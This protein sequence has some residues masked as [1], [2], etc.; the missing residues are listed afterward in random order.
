M[1]SLSKNIDSDK[2]FLINRSQIENRF[3]PKFYTSKYLNNIAKIESSQLPVV[4][5]SEV[6]ELISDG[7]HFTPK[8]TNKGVKFISV[9][10]VRKST[11]DLTNSK[12]IS[13]EEADKLDR[14]CKPKI[15]D[16]LL[17]KIGATFGLASVVS[18]T[19]RFQIFVSLALLRPNNG[20]NPKYLEIFLNS[21][22]AYIQYERVIKGAG[23]PDLHLEDIRKVKMPLPEKNE[24]EKIVS[25]YSMAFEEKQKK[26]QEAKSLRKSIDS[27][28]LEQLG[29]NIPT[30]D[31]SLSNRV[32]QVKWSEIFG[33]RLDGEFSQIYFREITK[34]VLEGKYKPS[35]IKAVTSFVESGSRPKGG[36]GQINSG[37]FS[38]GGEHVNDKCQVGF[39]KPKYIPI[40]YHEKI[41]STETKLNDIILVKDG[42]TTGKVGIIDSKKF[43]KQN[44][45]E[46]VFL[47]RPEKGIISPHFLVSY[48]F[49]SVGQI[50]LKRYI[51][52]A[53]VTGITKEAL[54]NILI[55]LPPLE[56][57]NE[58]T[59]HIFELRNRANQ[60]ELEAKN[61]IK[62]AKLKIE[63]RIL[64]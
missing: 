42:A 56:K 49:S 55:P 32:F 40:E 15:N 62:E 33:D 26:E 51:T 57:Q 60:L 5:L 50:L 28:L 18:T 8:Y 25:I 48:L 36:V 47:I 11:M 44:I 31:D 4:H 19:E 17:T 46:H 35:K 24:Q 9:K 45:N 63:E 38:I 14:R 1:Y 27:Y 41:K 52:G 61:E 20:I 58:I 2:A 37:V 54:R 12:F 22:L 53:T 13:E 34:S 43:T 10:D 3:E 30:R 29:I 59:E 23:V 64:G 6:T 39:G 16:I 7:T 21:N